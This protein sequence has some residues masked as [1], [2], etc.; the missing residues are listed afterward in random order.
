MSAKPF[1]STV[2]LAQW[3]E[4]RFRGYA[5]CAEL[6]G[7]VDYWRAF[8]LALGK[9]P[10]TDSQVHS[11]D[12]LASVTLA[13]DPRVWP[14]KLVRLVASYGEPLPALAAYH[15]I[16]H[17]NSLGLRN[18]A[19]CAEMLQEVAAAGV[20]AT[21]SAFLPML[22]RGRLPG[23]GVPFRDTDERLDALCTALGS[24]SGPHLKLL[25]ELSELAFAEKKIRPNLIA[26]YA[27]VALDSGFAPH[28]VQWLV[29]PLVLPAYLANALE[30]AAQQHDSMLRLGADDLAYRGP[31]PRRSPRARP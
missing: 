23:F 27:A 20:G 12:C 26:G 4:S 8:A 21:A 18:A 29:L 2:G 5:V 16:L 28:E 6:A 15:Y 30:G 14:H 17:A 13:V 24:D 1:T 7:R 31:P 22:R 9:P 3:G 19:K 11:L 10:L 25:G